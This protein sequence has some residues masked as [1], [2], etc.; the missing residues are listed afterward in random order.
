MI[1][2]WLFAKAS[3][4]SN[5]VSIKI[6]HSPHKIIEE[7]RM[8]FVFHFV[9]FPNFFKFGMNRFKCLFWP[10]SQACLVLVQEGLQVGHEDMCLAGDWNLTIQIGIT[11]PFNFVS[12]VITW[13]LSKA[14]SDQ[15]IKSSQ[16]D[17]KDKS[18]VILYISKTFKS[19]FN[20][21]CR[22]FVLT[23]LRLHSSAPSV[24]P[25]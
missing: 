13:I 10:H 11:E 14:S 21:M 2:Y 4:L 24:A 8:G 16:A 12:V 22:C 9:L 25:A 17:Y 19:I 1:Y 6:Q 15:I 18:W 23:F 5:I 7:L 3:W 20:K